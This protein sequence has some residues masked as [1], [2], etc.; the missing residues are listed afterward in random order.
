VARVV[1]Q[2]LAQ[3]GDHLR[4][5][6]RR[7]RQPGPDRVEQLDPGHEPAGSLRQKPQPLRGL[8]SQ[9]YGGIPSP[10][11]LID[12]IESERLLAGPDANH[13]EIQQFYQDLRMGPWR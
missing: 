2:G 1:S 6:L 13:I 4:Q 8:G 12:R 7:N 5:G 9:V 10:E 11:L 3:L